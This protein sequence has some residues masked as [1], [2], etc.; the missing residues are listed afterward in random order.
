MSISL[1]LAIP[2]AAPCPVPPRTARPAGNAACSPA[3]AARTAALRGCAALPMRPLP[4]G[5]G[6]ARPCRGRGSGIVCNASA[7]LSPPTTQWVSVA[8]AAVL[9]LAKGTGIHKSFLVPLFVLQAPTAVISWIKSEY[10]LWT[11]FLAL[12]VRLFLPFPGELELPLSTMLAVSVAPYQV[13]N[14][15]VLL[16][17]KETGIHK[18]WLMP[19]FAQQAPSSVIPWIKREYGLWTAFLAILV[20]LFLPTPGELELPLSTMWLIIIAPYQVMSLRGTQAGRILSLGVAV[21]LAFQY[22]TRN[23]GLGRAFRPGSIVATL[24]V[25]CITVTNVI[26][27]F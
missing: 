5:A 27:L 22:F 21:Y 13:M 6:A 10:G 20:R 11:A 12:V 14:V 7:Y 17:A 19:W 4:L 24:A 15:S 1:R 23:R 9:L 25:I 3:P 16:V 8:A 26:L 2:T 18:S